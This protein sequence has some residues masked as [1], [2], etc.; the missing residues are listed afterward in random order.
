MAYDYHYSKKWRLDR[1]RGLTRWVD[2]EPARERVLELLATGASQRAIADAAG[3]SAQTISKVKHGRH[4]HIARVV[5]KKILAVKPHQLHQRTG[6][7][8]V[9]RIGVVRRL[10]ALQALGHSA[11]TI[12]DAAGVTACVIHNLINQRGP[13]VSATNRDRAHAAFAQLWDK[14][15]A[16]RKVA[17]MAAAKGWVVPM[18]W[19]DI[20]DPNAVPDLG[21]SE[22]RSDKRVH[23][24]DI[25]D[26]LTFDPTATTKQ[27]AH[28]LHVTRD[29]IQQACRRAHRQDLLD[30]L[31]RNADLARPGQA[32]K[33]GTKAA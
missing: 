31:N 4:P 2:P 32:N 17:T 14:P 23:V 1:Q 12:G 25:A 8:F 29:A 20:D 13:W 26:L 16:S 28:R 5:A 7:N 11:A 21:H 27:I 10:Q 6:D 9:P 22:S 15:G 18:A 33:R 30:Q 3:V 24:D 19:D